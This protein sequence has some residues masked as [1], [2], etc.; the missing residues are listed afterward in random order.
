M[1]IFSLKAFCFAM[2][3]TFSSASS[4]SSPIERFKAYLRINTAHPYPDYAASTAFLLGQASEIGLEAQK[5]VFEGS[6]PVVVISWLGSKPELP[7]IL[8][9]SHTDVVAAEPE[10]WMHHPFAG[11]LLRVKSLPFQLL[12]CIVCR[13]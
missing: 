9:N 10:K 6:N 13:V 3:L 12:N 2:L 7:S 8:L 1:A 5:L 11:K 4:S